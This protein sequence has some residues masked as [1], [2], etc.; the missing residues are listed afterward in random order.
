MIKANTLSE[1][2]NWTEKFA[3]LNREFDFNFI[4]ENYVYLD[5]KNTSIYSLY[6]CKL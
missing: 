1:D 4:L 2:Y 3:Q 5:E 6:V